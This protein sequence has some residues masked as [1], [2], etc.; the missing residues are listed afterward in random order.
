[1]QEEH[2]LLGLLE[3]PGDGGTQEMEG[4]HTGDGE[5]C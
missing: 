5:V 1:M 4:V 2:P 3:V